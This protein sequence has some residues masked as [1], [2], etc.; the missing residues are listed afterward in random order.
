MAEIKKGF[1]WH[2]HHEVLVEWCFDYDERDRYIRSYK[3]LTEQKTRLR[4]FRPVRGKLPKE[5][6]KARQALNETWQAINKA[7]RA[8]DKAGQVLNK[9]VLNTEQVL[10]KALKENMLK[11]EALHR[12]ECPNCPWNGH[13]IFPDSK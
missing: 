3:P 5:V 4:L 13:T 9:Q 10:N 2:V 11:I 12:E 1:F 7:W 8:H 6:I